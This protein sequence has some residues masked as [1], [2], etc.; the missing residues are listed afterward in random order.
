VAL[1]GAL[2]SSRRPAAA[3]LE[4]G[5]MPYLAAAAA[6]HGFE[7]LQHVGGFAAMDA[8][9]A[10]LAMWL[11]QQLLQLRH[12]NGRPVCVL[13]GRQAELTESGAA[14]EQ[15][16]GRLSQRARQEWLERQ[17]PVVAF[18]L[19]QPDGSFAGC[20]GGGAQLLHHCPRG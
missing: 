20:T 15:Q 7:Q 12:G 11:S 3:G 2:F 17:G 10:C 8:H 5:T 19:L 6:V 16:G 1:A 13:Y 4:D 14:G 18:N 9:M